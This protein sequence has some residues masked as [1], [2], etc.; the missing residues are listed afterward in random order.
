MGAVIAEFTNTVGDRNN[1][2]VVVYPHWAD[3][4]LVAINA[5]LPPT[6]TYELYPEN[7]PDTLSVTGPKIFLVKPEHEEALETLKEI[8]PQGIVTYYES[9]IEYELKDFYIFYVLPEGS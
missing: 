8:Y 7:I 2:W 1:A 5:G 9:K 4:R 6:E 3:N